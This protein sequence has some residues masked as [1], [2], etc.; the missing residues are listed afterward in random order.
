MSVASKHEHWGGRLL[1]SRQLSAS[2]SIGTVEGEA[3][4]LSVVSKHE[5][6]RGISKVNW[7]SVVGKHKHWGGI[8]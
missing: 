5:H 1:F 6:W 8:R 4:W 2:A 7:L 3:S